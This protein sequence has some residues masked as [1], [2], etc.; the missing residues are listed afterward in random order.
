MKPPKTPLPYKRSV[1]YLNEGFQRDF[2]VKFCILAGVSSILA[3][4]LVYWLALNSTTV[5]IKDG[6]VAV[7]TT[8]EYL[9]PLM[10]QTVLLELVF[11]TI[12]TV[13]LTLIISFRIA[14]P[15][16]RLKLTLQGLGRGDLATQICLRSDDQLKDLAQVYNDAIY[17][18]NGQVKLLKNASSVDEF[19]RELAKF[20]TS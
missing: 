2:I 18:L 19:K 15:L 3:M 14:G 7:H 5:A 8:A 12:A 1:Y 6:H 16:H 4:S 11:G 17:Q 20:K 13:A 10:F 9:W